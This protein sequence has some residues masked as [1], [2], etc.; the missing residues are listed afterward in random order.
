MCNLWGWVF[1][2]YNDEDAWT[3]N[4]GP[5]PWLPGTA[6]EG[7]NPLSQGLHLAP[8]LRFGSRTLRISR[9]PPATQ[10]LIYNFHNESGPPH[11]T[12]EII[13]P[14]PQGLAGLGSPLY[15]SLWNP[16]VKNRGLVQRLEASR[17]SPEEPVPCPH[18][19][20]GTSAPPAVASREVIR[21]VRKQDRP[22][23][24]GGRAE[25][26]SFPVAKTPWQCPTCSAALP[27]GA[28]PGEGGDS[29]S[30]PSVNTGR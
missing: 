26:W 5:I 6:G 29:H 2:H 23:K 11:P 30:S 21:K 24:T 1:R 18:P 9:L 17:A 10:P 15:R 3:Q 4:L 19:E 8:G 7:Q 16:A 28:G 27:Q 14:P 20:R 25:P 22:P 12:L 13:R